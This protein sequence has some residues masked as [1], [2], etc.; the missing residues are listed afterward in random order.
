[1]DINLVEVFSATMHK[2]RD[3]LGGRI[4][5][6]LRSRPGV[7]IV[8]KIVTQSSD[9]AFH[10]LSITLFCHDSKAR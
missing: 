2:E 6:W 3:A 1:M 9:Q 5:D 7:K 10:C 4:T 8:E